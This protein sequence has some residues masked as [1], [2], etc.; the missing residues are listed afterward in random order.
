MSVGVAFRLLGGAV[1]SLASCSDPVPPSACGEQGIHWSEGIPGQSVS[2]PFNEERASFGALEVGSESFLELPSPPF[3]GVEAFLDSG[4][5]RLSYLVSVPDEGVFEGSELDLIVFGTSGFE[6]LVDGATPLVSFDSAS[7]TFV[8][9]WMVELEPTVF[10]PSLG[11]TLYLVLKQDGRVVRVLEPLNAFPSPTAELESGPFREPESIVAPRPSSLVSVEATGLASGQ[12][13][14]NLS[15]ATVA[16]SPPEECDDTVGQSGILVLENGDLV[17]GFGL[18]IPFGQSAIVSIGQTIGPGSILQVFQVDGLA[19]FHQDLVCDGD[20]CE[21]V[22][23]FN[24]ATGS[25]LFQRLP[26]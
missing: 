14:V 9:E 16:L 7:G 5:L 4:P 19:E 6:T 11:R 25:E 20:S 17:E 1:A 23:D 8:G 18:M 3:R 21:T 22:L 24:W 13:E 2:I 12:L 26:P 15:L 10:G